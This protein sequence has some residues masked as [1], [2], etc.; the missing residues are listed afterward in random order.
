MN[1]IEYMSHELKHTKELLDV[2]SECT[3][4]LKRNNEFPLSKPTSVCLIGSGARCTI[5]GGT[6]SGDGET[7]VIQFPD[8]EIT[9]E[10]ATSLQIADV[11]C[12][13][14]GATPDIYAD[15]LTEVLGIIKTLTGD[16]DIKPFET[17]ERAKYNKD[18][19]RWKKDDIIFE[20]K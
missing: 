14:W 20:I 3:L 5:K 10:I 16:N 1:K 17:P 15:N 19:I 12:E 2:A 7:Y 11:K 6:G 18:K 4:F 8:F 9:C 13:G